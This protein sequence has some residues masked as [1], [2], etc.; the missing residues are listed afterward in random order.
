MPDTVPG[1]FGWNL[2]LFRTDLTDDIYAVATTTSSGF[3][4]NIG[5]T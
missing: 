4:E 3:F 1:K 5:S 2:G